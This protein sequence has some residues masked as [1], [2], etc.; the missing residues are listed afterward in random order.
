VFFTLVLAGQI[1]AADVE[2]RTILSWASRAGAVTLQ[3]R[4][5]TYLVVVARR[6]NEVDRVKQLASECEVACSQSQLEEYTGALLANRSWAALREERL[7][8]A[9]DL[10]ESALQAWRTVRVPYPMQWLALFPL[11]ALAVQASRVDE[12]VG[13]AR[14]LLEEQQQR[15]PDE[16]STM[17]DAASLG[18]APLEGLARAVKRAE[19]LRYL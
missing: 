10:A 13:I 2:G 12:A 15:L 14:A 6:K 18:G 16:L 7:E 3:A 9:R 19:R 11:L 4:C 17:L 1:D 8:E 5:L